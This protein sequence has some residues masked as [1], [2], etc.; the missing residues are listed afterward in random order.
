MIFVVS[1]R[2]PGDNPS[3]MTPSSLERPRLFTADGRPATDV[4]A[5][6]G[7]VLRGLPVV[8]NCP[9]CGA[10]YDDSRIIIY[11]SARGGTHTSVAT[12]K[13]KGLVI[14]IV[15]MVIAIGIPI[16]AMAF[17]PPWRARAF[18]AY[19]VFVPFFIIMTV[20][21]IIQRRTNRHPDLA[22]VRLNRHGCV[23]HNDLSGPSLLKDA[24]P[25]LL[26]LAFVGWIAYSVLR[27]P[28]WE[29]STL[30][31]IVL[32]TVMLLVIRR[33]FAAAAKDPRWVDLRDDWLRGIPVGWEEIGSATVTPVGDGRHRLRIRSRRHN[34]LI[35]EVVNIQFESTADE[36]DRLAAQIE[37][38]RTSTSASVAAPT[39][40]M[41]APV[42]Q[43]NDG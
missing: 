6:C 24:W 29:M 3:D 33:R 10:A 12:A 14:S 27:G 21:G 30:P 11:G 22:Q 40:P 4:C 15:V 5:K 42:V 43:R 19:Y 26:A 18:P 9:E 36:A 25:Y 16:V 41:T 2:L 13:G 7:Y 32:W 31:T 28:A 35:R 39:T 38:W 20:M 34:W 1:A 17:S 37:T 23:Q 8:G